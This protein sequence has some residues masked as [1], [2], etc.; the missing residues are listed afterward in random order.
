[1]H[2]LNVTLENNW[3]NWKIILLM[4]GDSASLSWFCDLS[5]VVVCVLCQWICRNLHSNGHVRRYMYRV[6][7]L[8]GR[9]F[10]EIDNNP[11]TN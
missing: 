1:M 4:L 11:W 3:N 5:F 6:I 7:R 8:V 10:H 9:R 2:S